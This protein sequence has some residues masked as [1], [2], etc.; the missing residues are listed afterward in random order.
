MGAA[1]AAY[2]ALSA[3]SKPIEAVPNGIPAWQD[4][5]WKARYAR[6]NL[7]FE[8]APYKYEVSSMSQCIAF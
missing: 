3:G 1:S 6:E 4:G 5:A 2:C 7:R 8:A